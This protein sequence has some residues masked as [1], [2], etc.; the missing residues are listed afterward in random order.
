M[1]NIRCAIKNLKAIKDARFATLANNTSELYEKIVLDDLK[2]LD[3]AIETL[4]KQKSIS[5]IIKNGRYYC[6]K[7]DAEMKTSGYCSCGQRLY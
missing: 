5:R 1:V 3:M 7:C 6:P 2:S 4:E